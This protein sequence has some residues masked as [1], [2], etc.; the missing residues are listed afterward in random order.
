MR[1]ILFFLA[2]LSFQ[3]SA[4]EIINGTYD[5]QT[6]PAKKY[7]LYIPSTYDAGIPSK[8]IVGLH[9]WNTSKWDSESWAEELSE[10]AEANNCIVI[11]PDGGADGQIDDDIDTA[12]TSFL[13][14]EMIGQYNLDEAQMYLVGFS[15]GG[16]TVYTYGLNHADRFAGFMP[17]GAAVELSEVVAFAENAKDK[18]YYVI[19]GSQDSPNS[20]FTPIVNL[21]E[22]NE[23]CVETNLLSGIGHTVEFPDQFNILNDGFQWLL[24]AA[25][26]NIIDP[27][28]EFEKVSIRL[29]NNVLVSGEDILIDS[30]SALVWT[31]YNTDGTQLKKGEGNIVAQSLSAGIY[32]IQINQQESIRFV[33]R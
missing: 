12:F 24:N 13:I 26:C 14:D 22:D 23:A 32:F 1:F 31:I 20:R 29:R 10:L 5:F 4:Q 15:W 6:D 33:V 19:H 27:I 25:P 7:S 11:C 8:V 2:I 16:K 3:V 30:E 21:L 17:I 18:Y 9:P 28:V